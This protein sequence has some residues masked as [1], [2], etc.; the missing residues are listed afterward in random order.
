MAANTGVKTQTISV[1]LRPHVLAA[2][3]K[4]RAARG[5]IS[6]AEALKKML[7]EAMAQYPDPRDMPVE[8]IRTTRRQPTRGIAQQGTRRVHALNCG[9]P[10]CRPPK[11]KKD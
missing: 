1:R 4:W 2:L 6:R 5:G 7:E 9:C 10:I 8:P 3:D 11:V